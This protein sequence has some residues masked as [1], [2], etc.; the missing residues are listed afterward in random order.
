MCASDASSLFNGTDSL[1]HCLIVCAGD[2]LFDC[3]TC[4]LDRQSH[5]SL[6]PVLSVAATTRLKHGEVKLWDT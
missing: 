5:P 4:A 1:T 6:F 2:K 3:P